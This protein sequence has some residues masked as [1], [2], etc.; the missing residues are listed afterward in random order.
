[1]G[2]VKH[3]RKCFVIFLK[4]RRGSRWQFSCFLSETNE[5]LII[6]MAALRDQTHWNAPL[7]IHL[8]RDWRHWW[9]NPWERERLLLSRP[10]C[11]SRNFH[12]SMFS[13][14]IS[15]VRIIHLGDRLL[16]FSL[17]SCISFCILIVHECKGKNKSTSYCNYTDDQSMCSDDPCKIWM[18]NSQNL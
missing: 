7:H 13:G 15:D 14:N 12:V 17:T 3:K 9:S 18:S 8:R 5:H 10:L 16:S 6:G 2:E 4:H 1:M 11:H